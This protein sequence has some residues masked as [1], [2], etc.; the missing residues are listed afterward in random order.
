MMIDRA[1]VERAPAALSPE[2]GAG[3]VGLRT[4]FTKGGAAAGAGCAC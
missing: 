3:K 1:A 4:R 2:E